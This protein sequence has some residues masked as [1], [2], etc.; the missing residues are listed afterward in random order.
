MEPFLYNLSTHQV[1]CLQARKTQP[2]AASVSWDL[3]RDHWEGSCCCHACPPL[4]PQ[5]DSGVADSMLLV[6]HSGGLLG[7][8][9]WLWLLW[10][11]CLFQLFSIGL[12]KLWQELTETQQAELVGAQAEAVSLCWAQPTALLQQHKGL[13]LLSPCHFQGLLA[14]A[15]WLRET[16]P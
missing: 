12:L 14:R 8:G 2:L 15:P 13:W 10:S 1:C 5:G 4:E 9:R 16:P 6:Y 3:G 11:F 7:T